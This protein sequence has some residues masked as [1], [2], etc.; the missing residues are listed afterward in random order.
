MFEKHGRISDYLVEIVLDYLRWFIDTLSMHLASYFIKI[1][2]FKYS[3][4][5]ITMHITIIESFFQIN[6]F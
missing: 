1:N 3:L 6:Y 4:V 5:T 2:P